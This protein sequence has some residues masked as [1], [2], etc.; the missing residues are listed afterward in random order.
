MEN[1][2]SSET[3]EHQMVNFLENLERNF[4]E[5]L[6]RKSRTRPQEMSGTSKDLL[7]LTR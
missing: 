5:N 4:P 7:Y 1:G 6:Q 3:G 2:A